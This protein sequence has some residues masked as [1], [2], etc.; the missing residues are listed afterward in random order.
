MVYILGGW[1]SD[2]AANWAR[3]GADLADEYERR[4]GLDSAHL[5]RIAQINF[6]NAKRNPNAQTRQWAFG[7]DSFTLDDVANPVVEG[8]TRKQDCGQVTDGAA[9]VF[10]ASDRKAAEYAARRGIPLESL[11]QIKGWG[12]RSAP[13]SYDAKVRA[14]ADQPRCLSPG[15]PGHR[16]RPPSGRRHGA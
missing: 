6:E 7:E 12:H 8:R 9:V 11:A 5:M 4:Y 1:Q 15:P 13:I 10:L 3:Q 16:G 14:S 2:F